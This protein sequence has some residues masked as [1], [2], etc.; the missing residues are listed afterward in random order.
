MQV[1]PYLFFAGRCEEAME[2]YVRTLGAEL[3]TLKRYRESPEPQM[4]ETMP[5]GYADKVMQA[6]FRL[7]GTE[8][9]ASDGSGHKGFP[10][11]L[12]PEGDAEALI[13]FQA[14]AEGGRVVQALTRT[15]FSSSFGM[16]TD[17]F[18][19]MWM[20]H[21]PLETFPSACGTS[22]RS[23]RPRHQEQFVS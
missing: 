21:V 17:R 10:L 18:G 11:C 22:A 12:K 8:F 3:M 15:C 16:V 1:H 23:L 13:V 2:F 19:I 20:V 6:R 14:L 7:G 9:M 5:A 4:P